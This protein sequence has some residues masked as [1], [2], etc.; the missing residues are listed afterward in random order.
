MFRSVFAVLA[1][2]LTVASS[3]SAATLLVNGSFEEG[4][5]GPGQRG[6]LF[7]NL[8][9]QGGA[10]WDIWSA[11]PGWNTA[12]GKPGIEVQVSGTLPTIL[13]Q[14]WRHYVELDSTGNSRIWQT[15]ALGVGRYV[16][17]FWYSPRTA[18]PATN[19]IAY[20]LNGNGLGL[21]FRGRIGGPATS[22]GTAVGVWTEVRH[23]FEI[24][25][26]G[27]YRLHFEAKGRSDSYGGLLDNV[28]LMSVPAA[29][30]VPA[31]GALLGSALLLGATVARRHRRRHDI[32]AA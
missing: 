9:D 10:L 1:F 26:A 6:S 2:A 31:A 18:D 7:G 30:P 8:S 11:L 14:D 12:K 5:D 22:G 13:A 16:L 19:E 4:P 3:A 27:N 15:V 24:L 20:R 32:P 25:S 21:Q 29:V 23:E 28:V 17:S